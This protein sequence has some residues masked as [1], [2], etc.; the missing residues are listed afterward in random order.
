MVCLRNITVDTLHKGNTEDNNNSN[1]NNSSIWPIFLLETSVLSKKLRK[2]L[3]AG[4]H[5]FHFFV[6]VVTKFNTVPPNNS[7]SSEW[8]LLRVIVI[9]PIFLEYLC[10]SALNQKDDTSNNIVLNTA[11]IYRTATSFLVLLSSNACN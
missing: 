5:K 6:A 2:I 11:V 10:T 1:N 9:A 7:G 4:V 3:K 8:N